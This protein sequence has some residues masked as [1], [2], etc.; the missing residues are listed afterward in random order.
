MVEHRLHQRLA[1][2]EC[3]IDR[4]HMHIGVG[5]AGHHPPLHVG[6][7][8]MGIEH[9]N[10]RLRAITERFHCCAACVTGRRH[11]DGGALAARFQRV[12]HHAAKELH[13]EILERQRRPVKQ[14][15][16]ELIIAGLHQRHR[17]R[18]AE[19]VI[20]L[21]C[22]A[23]EIGLGNGV[24]DKRPD[25]LDRDFGI[26]TAC[27]GRDL[28]LAQARPGFR[29]IESAVAGE[30]REHDIDKAKRWGFAPG[31]NVAHGPSTKSLKRLRFLRQRGSEPKP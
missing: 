27:E 10:V 23:G 8:A 12:V 31:G 6:D 21:A 11:H 14:L 19:G 22:H 26:G 28:L 29:H 13:G 18:M 1:I 2:V 4:E 16:H 7:A 17:R 25:H 15:E 20:G 24:T 5:N 9:N 30:T 3:A